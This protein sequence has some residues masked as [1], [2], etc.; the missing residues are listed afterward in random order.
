MVAPGE[1]EAGELLA[2]YRDV[3]VLTK[4]V[5]FADLYGHLREVLG[6]PPITAPRA[7]SPGPRTRSGRR[8]SGRHE[9]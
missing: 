1:P 6:P 8:T 4:P 7:S 9:I 5:G 3:P 2:G